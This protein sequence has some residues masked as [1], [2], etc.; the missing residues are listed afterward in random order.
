VL[1]DW[2]QNDRHKSTVAAYSLRA[3]HPFPT[4]SAPLGWDELERAVA[5]GDAG[6]LLLSPDAVLARVEADGDLFAPVLGC[7]QRL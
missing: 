7:V 4:V 6:A 5:V 1:V 2:G 3:K